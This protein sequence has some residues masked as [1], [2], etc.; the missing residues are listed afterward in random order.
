LFRHSFLLWKATKA[1]SPK[2]Y[3]EIA[4]EIAK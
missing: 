1:F 2:N 4:A 3:F